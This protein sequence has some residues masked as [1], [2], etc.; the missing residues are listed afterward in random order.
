MCINTSCAKHMA[1]KHMQADIPGNYI[2]IIIMH[3]CSILLVH[4]C[5]VLPGAFSP[6]QPAIIILYLSTELVGSECILCW[7]GL[8]GSLVRYD[9]HGM[10]KDHCR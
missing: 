7:L 8:P 3:S 2:R 1:D 6:N 4:T 10:G 9:S 5:S